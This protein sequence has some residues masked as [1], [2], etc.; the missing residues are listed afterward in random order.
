VL[1]NRLAQLLFRPV[2]TVAPIQ[3]NALNVGQ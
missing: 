1:E 3:V 2:G